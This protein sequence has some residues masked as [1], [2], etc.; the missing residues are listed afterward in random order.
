MKL[1]NDRIAAVRTPPDD[2][3]PGGIVLPDSYKSAEIAQGIVAVVGPGRILESGER[4][5]MHTKVGDRIVFMPRAGMKVP[6]ATGL[7]YTVFG[8]GE[9]WAILNHDNDVPEKSY[10]PKGS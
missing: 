9:A 1:I 8:E 4:A 7:T 2:K 10:D 5:P 6:V 3:T